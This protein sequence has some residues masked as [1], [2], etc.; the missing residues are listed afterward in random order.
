MRVLKP[1]SDR[2][3]DG[4]AERRA[5]ETGADGPE[6]HAHGQALGDV[7]QRDGEHEQRGA[8]QAGPDA[9]GFRVGGQ[10][11]KE[12]LALERIARHHKLRY[13]LEVTA[14]LF[15]CPCRRIPGDWLQP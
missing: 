13:S 4:G 2:E 5:L 1:D 8:P 12:K 14:G 3:R 9:F 7:V 11:V 6:G 10:R 15:L